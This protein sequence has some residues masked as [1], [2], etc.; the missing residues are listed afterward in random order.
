MSTHARRPAVSSRAASA[1][2]HRHGAEG[3]ELIDRNHATPTRGAAARAVKGEKSHHAIFSDVTGAFDDEWSAWAMKGTPKV[4]HAPAR[5]APD[6][7]RAYHGA[8]SPSKMKYTSPLTRAKNGEFIDAI[9]DAIDAAIGAT[10]SSMSVVG[11]WLGD[12]IHSAGSKKNDDDDDRYSSV[13]RRQVIRDKEN[14]DMMTP[15]GVKSFGAPQ[16]SNAMDI[17][18]E[19]AETRAELAGARA[20]ERDMATKFESL[21]KQNLALQKRQVARENKHDEAN[22]TMTLVEQLKA[23]VEALMGEKAQMARDINALTRENKDMRTFMVCNGL[24]ANDDEEE[25]EEE[26]DNDEDNLNSITDEGDMS[27]ASSD[28]DALS[29]MDRESLEREIAELEASL[30]AASSP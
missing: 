24:I 18:R 30:S 29:T 15:P 8:G 28:I 25:E 5:R 6:S 12:V 22:E 13:A 9:D 3:E 26:F 17:E 19:L 1:V 21:K 10:V 27:T 20:R 11:S 23:Q 14:I 4:Q 2:N 16:A 7:A